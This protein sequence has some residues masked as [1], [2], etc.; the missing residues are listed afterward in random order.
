[1]CP[2]N[3]THVE[4]ATQSYTISFP[5]L[6]RCAALFRGHYRRHVRLPSG[7]ILR[8][9]TEIAQFISICDANERKSCYSE[10]SNYDIPAPSG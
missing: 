6:T 5:P 10:F 8:R 4:T 2:A 3:I 7:H 9:K 1:M